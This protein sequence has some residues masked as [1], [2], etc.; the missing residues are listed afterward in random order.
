M[1]REEALQQAQS[2]GLTLR[3]SDNASGYRGV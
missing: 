3:K 1:T 2:E